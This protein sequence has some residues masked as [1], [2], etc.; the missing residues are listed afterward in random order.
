MISFTNAKINLGL[1]ITEKRKDGYH[2]IETVFYPVKLYD[3]IEIHYS[4]SFDFK[5]VGLDIPDDGDNLCVKAY[6]LLRKDFSLKPMGIHLLKNIPIG[7]GLGGGSSD[8]VC[9]LKAINEIEKLGLNNDQLRSYASMLGADCPFFVDNKPV[10]ASGIGT[11]FEP[12]ALD[13]S[14]YYIVLIKP[15]VH[16]STQDAY[17]NVKPKPAP[18]DL[19]EVI[20]LPIQDWKFHLQNDFEDGIFEIH[21][22][23]KEIKAQLYESGAIYS[24]MSG[25]G[26]SVFGI[27]DKPIKLDSL[28]HLGHIFYPIELD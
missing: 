24:A 10:Y 7:A 27:F 2:N 28:Q 4:N 13:L 3:V 19:R 20:Q 15:D 5:N 16:V 23:I 14:N 1:F 17:R 18:I 25:S 12:I 9:V 6:N 22:K 11:D 8:A 21:P 26:S